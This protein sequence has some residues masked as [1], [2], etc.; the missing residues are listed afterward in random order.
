MMTILEIALLL[1]AP[2]I[3]SFIC[4]TADRFG[5]P[6]GILSGRS[7]CDHC[8]RTLTI[9]DLVPILSFLILRGQSRCC[10]KPLRTTLLLA[11]ILSL[12]LTLWAAT[13]TDGTIFVLSCLLAWTLLGLTLIDLRLFRLPDGG[14]L[15]LVVTGLGVSAMGWS[16]L[17][18]EHVLAAVLGFSAFAAIGAVW[19]RTRGID[20]L[21]LGD[22][23]LLA[24]GGAW[25][26][27]AGLPSVLIW[28]CLSGLI[29][30]GWLGW[31]GGALDRQTAIPFGPALALGI[32][33]TW[34]HG[35]VVLT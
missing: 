35:P 20:G 14:T 23:K 7:Q 25:T 10:G 5:G 27:L 1:C 6:R 30:A 9:R 19:R 28:A 21:G 34:L 33:L 24:A 4:L 2:A 32:W 3:G 15:A 18:L 29:H 31:K 11:E 22:A 8:G 17:I 16:G 12:L 13:I 26:G